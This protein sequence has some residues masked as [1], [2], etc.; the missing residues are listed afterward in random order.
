MDGF[1]LHL[2]TVPSVIRVVAGRQGRL[3]P[4]LRPGQRGC[5]GCVLVQL[6]GK[7]NKVS[8]LGFEEWPEG[9]GLEDW[10]GEPEYAASLEE[11]D[12]YS[13]RQPL[14]ADKEGPVL[15]E[16][17]HGGP[18]YPLDSGSILIARKT[19]AIVEGYEFRRPGSHFTEYI[20]LQSDLFKNKV[21][22]SRLVDER[23]ALEL[24]PAAAALLAQPKHNRVWLFDDFLLPAEDGA[25]EFDL[26]IPRSWLGP[27]VLSVNPALSVVA[28]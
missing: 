8:I 5:L 25:T 10:H 24:L 19:P 22:G 11:N 18:E 23:A 3:L 27:R 7:A 6:V 9:V 15:C 17:F 21:T 12:C 20:S 1:E 2:D 13:V 26:E 28:A 4:K 16:P 14:A